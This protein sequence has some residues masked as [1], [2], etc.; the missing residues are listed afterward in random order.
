MHLRPQEIFLVN[1]ALFS[2]ARQVLQSA[3]AEYN[4]KP[5]GTV[6]ARGPGAASLNYDRVFPRDFAVSAFA[7]L[8][9]GRAD[10]SPRA[11]SR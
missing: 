8:I 5:V 11:I 9:N 10:F 2:K 6:A 7:F 1:S 3:V 4:G